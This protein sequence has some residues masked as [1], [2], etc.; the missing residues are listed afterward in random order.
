M[1]EVAL[2]VKVVQSEKCLFDDAFSDSNTDDTLTVGLRPSEAVD[3][4]P[5]NVGDE[6]NV[7]TMVACIV[8]R[9]V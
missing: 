3:V 2:A 7:R 8:G 9:V 5:K 6:T 1:H 4:C